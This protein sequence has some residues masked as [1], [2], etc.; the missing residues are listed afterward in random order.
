MARAKLLLAAEL[1]AHLDLTRQRIEQ[2]AAEGV[3]E[4]DD[5]GRYDLYDCRL[6]YIRFLCALRREPAESAELRRIRE[7]KAELLELRVA[8]ED[9]RLWDMQMVHEMVT[10]FAT[11]I[12]N[13]GDALPFEIA[14]RSA[15]PCA[16]G[17]RPRWMRCSPMFAGEL[18]KLSEQYLAKDAAEASEES[19]EAEAA[20]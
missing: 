18:E 1:A 7:A 15:M 12:K 9:G 5:A 20:T 6:A 19:A 8:E 2:L 14:G 16:I 13:R 11:K 4:C 10:M 3:I 17:C